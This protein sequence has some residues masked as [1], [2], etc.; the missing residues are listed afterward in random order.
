[1]AKTTDFRGISED[2]IVLIDE[3]DIS[4]ERFMI[5]IEGGEVLGLLKLRNQEVYMF[6]ATISESNTEV[7]RMNFDYGVGVV[8][9]DQLVASGQFTSSQIVDGTAFAKQGEA[10]VA[11]TQKMTEIG[12]ERPVIV[13]ATDNQEKLYEFWSDTLKERNIPVR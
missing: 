6:S 7:L 3:G 12:K 4:L 8:I 10:V 2:A 1:M 5:L 9:E 11:M 13:F